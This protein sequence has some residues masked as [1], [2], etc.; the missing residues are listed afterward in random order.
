M[1]KTE[2][3]ELIA[4]GEPSFVE[5][6]RDAE[7]LKAETIAEHVICFSNAKGGRILLGVED[8]GAITGLQNRFADYGH[9]ISQA[10]QGHARAQRQ[11]AE[12]RTARRESAGDAVGVSGV[13]RP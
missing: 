11:R 3:L 2:L 13:G 7:D 8:D 6:K 10:V 12:L 1:N 4:K 5:F 9:W